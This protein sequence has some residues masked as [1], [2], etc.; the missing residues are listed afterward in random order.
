MSSSRKESAE[1]MVSE[2]STESVPIPWRN[3]AITVDFRRGEIST[4]ATPSP[5]VIFANGLGVP[6]SAWAGTLERLPRQYTLLTYDRFGQG[7]T[8]PLPDDVPEELRDGA[9]AARDLDELIK[10]LLVKKEGVDL[11]AANVFVVA[12]SIGVAIVRLLINNHDTPGIKGVLFLD[13]SIV[14]SDFV[15]IYPPPSDDEPEELTRTRDAT[16][17]IFH[18][19]V[20]NKERLN[21]KTF[22]KLLPLAEEPALRGDPYLT[23]VAHDPN[24]AFGE[25]SEKV[26]CPTHCCLLETSTDGH[27][28]SESAPSMRGNTS[29]PTGRTTIRSSYCLCPVEKGKAQL[30]P[31]GRITSSKRTTQMLLLKRLCS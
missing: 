7:E 30:S 29:S 18:P 20:P 26:T 11:T 2:L 10:E 4:E 8:P 23:V 3:A 31:R 16:R 5:I 14:N 17:R 22:A 9:A 19:D 27:L 15:S 1:Q 12:H 24:V 21:R 25:A 28:S 13:P 6:K